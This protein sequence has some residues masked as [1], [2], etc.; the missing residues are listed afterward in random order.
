[1]PQRD[2]GA[3]QKLQLVRLGVAVDPPFGTHACIC[4]IGRFASVWFIVLCSLWYCPD[5]NSENSP[6]T[7]KRVPAIYSAR[8]SFSDL[9][10][11]ERSRRNHL[12]CLLVRLP[13]ELAVVAEQQAI[14]AA[15][16]PEC[17]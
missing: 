5:R 14:A 4:A 16:Q 9:C 8:R 6:C 3:V 15:L 12:G 13:T 11:C 1:M 7:W 10:S 2:L 17:I